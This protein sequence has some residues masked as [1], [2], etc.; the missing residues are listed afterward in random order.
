MF[1]S[2]KMNSGAIA[3]LVW[4]VWVNVNAA[5]RTLVCTKQVGRDR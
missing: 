2:I 4:F 3:L 1:G 5:I